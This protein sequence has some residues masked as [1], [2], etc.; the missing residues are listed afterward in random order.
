MNREHTTW[1]GYELQRLACKEYRESLDK[2]TAEMWR[3]RRD[4]KR[5]TKFTRDLLSGLGFRFK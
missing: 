5:R 4:G 3:K 1:F 2:H